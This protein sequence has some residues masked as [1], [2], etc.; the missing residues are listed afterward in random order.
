MSLLGSIF[1]GIPEK[2][3]FH[4]FVEDASESWSWSSIGCPR[5]NTAP[6]TED[7]K[8][9]CIVIMITTTSFSPYAM[10]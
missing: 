8:P 4:K 3:Y 1:T 5:A 2:P 9:A 6:K 7:I 10:K